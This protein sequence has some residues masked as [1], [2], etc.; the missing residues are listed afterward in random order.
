MERKIGK[1]AIHHLTLVMIGCYVIG[2][3]LQLINPNAV[4]FMTLDPVYILQGQVWRIITWIIIPPESMST[5][6]LGIFFTLVMLFFYLSIGDSLEKS[7]G[8]FRYN[9][10]IFGGMLITVIAAFLCYFIFSAILGQPVGIGGAFSTYYITT[11]IFLAFAATFPDARVMLYFVIPIKVKWLGILYAAFFVYDMV[12]YFRLIISGGIF[13][14]I[15]VIAMIA[16]LLNFII[17]FFSTRSFHRFSPGEQKRRRDFRKAMEHANRAAPPG[18]YAERASEKSK[19]TSFPA[20]NSLPRHRCEICG[21][22]EI[23]NP[24]L[25]FRYCSKCSGNHEYCMDHLFTHK[26]IQQDQ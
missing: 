25:E 2:Y 23:S 14:W 18:G 12:G 1:Y 8:A 4:S 26:H 7:W 6:G 9:V 20:G 11:S 17:F 13:Y 3:V 19:G 10:F 5:D 15:Y 16:S 24:E 22:T 21:R